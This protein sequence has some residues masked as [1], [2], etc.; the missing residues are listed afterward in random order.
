MLTIRT[1]REYLLEPKDMNMFLD[2]WIG[3]ISNIPL[4]SE[5]TSRI[6][7]VLNYGPSKA[8]CTTIKVV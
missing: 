2:V 8:R 1:S 7:A 5:G 4:L 6:Y 3:T